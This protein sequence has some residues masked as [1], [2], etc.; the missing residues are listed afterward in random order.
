MNE[1]FDYI[2]DSLFEFAYP[3]TPYK[4]KAG[5]TYYSLSEAIDMYQVN[6]SILLMLTDLGYLDQFWNTYLYGNFTQYKNLIVAC[7]NQEAYEVLSSSFS[8]F[9][10]RFLQIVVFKLL[11]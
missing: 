9:I 5:Y 8:L 4:G 1:N 3:Q 11:L 2:H 7:I 6:N 10:H